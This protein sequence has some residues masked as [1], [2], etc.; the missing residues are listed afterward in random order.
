[1]TKK[2]APPDTFARRLHSLLAEAGMTAYRLAQLAGLPNQTVCRY[3]N[4][5]RE[6]TY[7]NAVKLARALAVS[8]E[9]FADTVPAKEQPQ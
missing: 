9:V 5:E 3:L 7:A 8:V 1:M 4:G 2:Q 6:P